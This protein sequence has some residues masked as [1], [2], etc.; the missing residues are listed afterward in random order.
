MKIKIKKVRDQ[1]TLP[2]Y[3]TAQAAGFD[4]H[5]AIEQ[6]ITINPGKTSVIPTGV[7]VE[8]PAGYE[9]QVRPRSGLAFK[10]HVTMVNGVGT[11]DADYRG[12]MNV[13]LINLGDQSFTVEPDMRVAQGVIARHEVAE[14]QEVDELSITDRGKGGFGSTG[15]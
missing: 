13:N 6:P 12:E 8:L 3:Q 9:L 4:F 1:A 14:W 15:L 10:Y 7:A 5:A 2:A 11:I